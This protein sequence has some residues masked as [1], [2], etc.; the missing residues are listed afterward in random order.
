MSC[1]YQRCDN[2][3]K[4]W[5]VGLIIFSLFV[6]SMNSAVAD[7]EITLTDEAGD[8]YDY[9]ADENT[10]EKPNID[11]RQLTYSKEGNTITF[12][13][14]V[15]GIIEDKGN[16]G[17][18]RIYVDDAYLEE[19][20]SS[21]NDTELEEFFND[22]EIVAYSFSLES[23]ENSYTI[24]YVN[25]EALAF[26]LNFQ[27]FESDFSVD[28]DKLTISF[29]YDGE[30]EFATIYALTSEATAD[31][32]EYSDE[33]Y[34]EFDSENGDTGDG[35]DGDAG[36]QDTGDDNGSGGTDNTTFL[37]FIAIIAA[38]CIIGVAVLIFVIRR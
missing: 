32:N 31:L 33:I 29:E 17:I 21:M 22:T 11:I 28:E 19:L 27:L 13:L 2:M 25:G 20:T 8:V 12:E 34:G 37:F 14:V 35:D 38:I 24:M 26:D 15:E 30:D 16:I 4:I 1:K 6:V 3:K 23:L 18:Y 7:D 10:T 36:D 9:I 5:I